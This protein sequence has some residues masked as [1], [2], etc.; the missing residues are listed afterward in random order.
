M[1]LLRVKTD[2]PGQILA[3]LSVVGAQPTPIDVDSVL[4]VASRL[5]RRL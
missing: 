4:L 1:L 2:R 3:R 5:L